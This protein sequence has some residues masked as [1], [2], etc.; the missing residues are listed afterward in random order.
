[1][2][3][4]ISLASAGTW[5]ICAATSTTATTNGGWSLIEIRESDGAESTD[6]GAW[7][8]EA[9]LSRTYGGMKQDNACESQDGMGGALMRWTSE[10]LSVDA[11]PGQ[12][13]T[14]QKSCDVTVSARGQSDASGRAELSQSVMKGMARGDA[15]SEAEAENSGAIS[16]DSGGGGRFAGE[17]AWGVPGAPAAKVQGMIRVGVQAAYAGATLDIPGWAQI[18]AWD[19]EVE[20]W[21]REG[22]KWIHIEGKAPIDI[23]FGAV[24]PGRGQVCAIGSA[25]A[26]SRSV[27]GGGAIGAA[28]IEFSMIPVKSIDEIDAR[29]AGGPDFGPCSCY[30]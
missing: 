11:L 14:S 7:F 12:G 30:D 26:G 10:L 6:Q 5:P 13:K 2:L 19:G 3:I 25:T 23:V 15:V 18:D 1:M 17:W 4:L 21:V 8:S 24:V 16:V 27:N 29:P 22:S 20:G 28:G 9:S